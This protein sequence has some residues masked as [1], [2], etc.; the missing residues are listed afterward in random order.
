M[1]NY[2][3]IARRYAEQVVSGKR[4][5]C[6]WVRL[7]C[8]RALL[9]W[10][11]PPPGCR[12]VPAEATRICAFC[13]LITEI[14]GPRAGQHLH[15]TDWQV[16]LLAQVFG[17]LRDDGTR[18]YRRAYI[19][20]PRGNG[21]S[22]LSAAVALYMLCAD[23][24]PGAECYSFAVTRDQA[25]IVFDTARE[26]ARKSQQ[27][28][29]AFGLDVGQHSLYVR[30]TASKFEPKSS[31][32]DTLEGLNTHFACIDELHAHKTR[33]VYDVVETSLGK[34]RNNLLW[35]ITTAG[36]DQAGVCYELHRHIQH[37]LEGSV[38]DPAQFGLIYATDPDDDW[39]T[40]EAL[41]RANPNWGVSVMPDVVRSL[42]AKAITIPSAANGFRAKHLNQWVSAR[43]S[44]MDMQAWSACADP[45]LTLDELDGMP[46]WVGLDLADT[47]DMSCASFVFPEIG[48][49]GRRRYSVIVRHYLPEQTIERGENSHYRG[50]RAMGR[51]ITAGDAALSGDV[52]VDDILQ[53]SQRFQIRGVL[54]DPMYARHVIE[55]LSLEGLQCIVMRPVVTN[56]SAPMKELEGLV[57]ERRLRHDGDPVLQ[58]MAANVV[59]KRDA[60]DNI[61]PVKETR[62]A[63]IDGIVAL[64]M[65]LAAAMQDTGVQAAPVGVYAL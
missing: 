45:S 36:S 57:L 7:S 8:E 43:E 19:E 48:E 15:L 26:M 16:F 14:K 58:W 32:A 50:W 46:C 42:Q 65:A 4:P 9:E 33:D 38:S 12:W 2:T 27:L 22:T 41:I 40:E 62:A 1:R 28:R 35:V 20:V 10:K 51:I 6:R 5:A 31:D 17:W 61:R 47:T 63:K 3:Q 55:R 11:D 21:K 34:R 29:S 37:T 23:G 59:A 44:W 53:L 39:T 54:Y 60:N 24:E 49:D 18:R 30:E 56:L 52:I 13:E 64:I 25:R